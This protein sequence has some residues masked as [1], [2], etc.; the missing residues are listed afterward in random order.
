M[1]GLY[2]HLAFC[3]YV[4]PYCDFAKWRYDELHAQRYLGALRAE[5]AH[6]PEF[7]AETLFVGGGTPNTYPPDT[8]RALVRE[9]ASRFALPAGAEATIEIN[10]DL[11]LC[12]GFA[13]HV[14]AG[15]NRLSIGVQSFDPRELRVL[16]R[17]H[18][19]ADV[20]EVVR[21]ARAAGFR[22]ISLDLIFGTPGQTATSWRASLG[23]AIVLGIDHISTYGLTVEPG[24]PY[25]RL[26]ARDPTAFPSP[27]AQADL[28]GIAI[29]TLASAGFEQ[30]EISN[31]ARAGARCRHNA[32]YWANGEYL[33]LGAGAA[34][35]LGGERKTNTRDR[36]EYEDAALAGRPVPAASERLDGLARVGEAAMLALRTA[37]GVDFQSFAERYGIDFSEMYGSILEDFRTAGLIRVSPTHAALTLRGRFVAN[38][39][40]GAF[41]AGA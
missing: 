18:A 39:V 9:M 4:C 20:A 36:V 14:A 30:Y 11:A 37:E 27:D 24:T 1:A 3:P 6:A 13:A 8:V 33:G 34:T 28:Y 29:E 26:E 15:L 2:L 5:A 12:D 25:A 38:D 40:C 23:A 10:P 7:R 41:L 22:T 16:G 19:P 17:R 32:N 31:F 35:Y 21:R